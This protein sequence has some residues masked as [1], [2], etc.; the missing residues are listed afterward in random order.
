MIFTIWFA[1]FLLLTRIKATHNVT[2]LG[3]LHIRKIASKNK[4]IYVLRYNPLL[5]GFIAMVLRKFTIF[6]LFVIQACILQMPILIL[7]HTLP[8]YTYQ[9]IFTIIGYINSVCNLYDLRIIAIKELH[10]QRC[11]ATLNVFLWHLLLKYKL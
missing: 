5:I 4:S 1:E 11:I 10:Q 6:N 3:K 8:A 9:H 2:T 7:L